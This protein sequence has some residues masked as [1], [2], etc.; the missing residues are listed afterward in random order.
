MTSIFLKGGVLE[1]I[2]CAILSRLNLRQSWNPFVN[3]NNKHHMDW[4]IQ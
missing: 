4:F 3:L 1:E 2:L